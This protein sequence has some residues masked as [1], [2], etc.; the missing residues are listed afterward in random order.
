MAEHTYTCADCTKDEGVAPLECKR[1]R[2]CS[3]CLVKRSQQ[4]HPTSI[5]KCRLCKSIVK[6]HAQRT[7]KIVPESYKAALESPP[8]GQ[9][10]PMGNDG[11]AASNSAHADHRSDPEPSAETEGKLPGIHIFVD[12]S[13]IWIEAKKLHAK[14]YKTLSTDPRVRIDMGKLADVLANGRPVEQ[15][16]LYGSEP[17]PI[18]TVWKKIKEKAGWTVKSKRRDMIT[19]KEKQIDTNLV[20]DVTATA[21]RTPVQ[22]R[23]TI[24]LVTG[25]A[26]VLP[27][28][29]K[30]MEEKQWSVE[31]YMWK[32]A[33]SKQL[34]YYGAK[35]Q[36]RIEIVPLD[37][38]LDHLAFTNMKFSVSN[39]DYFLRTVA[40]HGVV[41]T[42]EK[43]AFRRRVPTKKWF[44]QL[45]NIAQWPF[46]YYWFESKTGEQTD[47][48]VIV[49]PP[50]P[51]AGDCH[52]DITK[53]LRNIKADSE[54]DSEG[55]RLPLVIEAYTFHQFMAKQKE[56]E[57]DQ[58]SPIKIMDAV[59]EEVGLL[60]RNDIDPGN[61][62]YAVCFSEE[63]DDSEWT[64]VKRRYQPRRQ[65]FSDPCRYGMHCTEG[66]QCPFKH[67]D[68]DKVYFKK[69]GGPGNPYRKVKP[70]K[71]FEKKTCWRSK[72]DCD[73]AHGEED[74]HCLACGEGGHFTD[75]CKR[76]KFNASAQL[77]RVSASS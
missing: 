57:Q 32:D 23:T 7:S 14:K 42:M 75:N 8:G 28:L 1:H 24:V 67:S 18:D 52:F 63:D 25:D 19:G 68:E 74:A 15:G 71:Y 51:E 56:K 70:C 50:Y 10:Q 49:F 26:N 36:R 60:D 55:Y 73:G 59:L 44:N 27:A 12:D 16:I 69:N 61:D 62:D 31:V 66:T 9:I 11:A 33:L 30:V 53:F 77:K 34:I 6:L 3:G 2:V 46:R 47:D 22:E 76:L 65:K 43:K 13:N 41:L 21:I 35:N 37:S 4:N 40:T 5:L 39:R 20:A 64:V 45:E 38:Y 72:E 58:N 17:P 54:D 48:L 29:E